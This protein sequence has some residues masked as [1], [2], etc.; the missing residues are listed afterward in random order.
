MT[1]HGPLSV[2]IVEHTPHPQDVVAF[3]ARTCY[4]SHDQANIDSDE[5]LIRSVVK[6]GHESVLEHAS[7][8]FEITCS[9]VVTHE[10]VR[11][12][13]AAYSQRSQRYVK[14]AE[15]SYYTPAEILAEY[16]IAVYNDAMEDAWAH[17]RQLLRSGLKPEIARYVLPNACLSTIVCTWNLREIRHIVKLRTSKA[18]QPEMRIVAAMILERARGVIP[19]VFAD[20]TDPTT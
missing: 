6:R 19:G 2:E 8:T 18:A 15:P 5:R 20:L 1:D 14:E 10:L 11:H 3:A 9:R 7:I 16:D 12:R 13:L 4:A 17:Y